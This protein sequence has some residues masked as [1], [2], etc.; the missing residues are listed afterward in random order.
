MYTQLPRQS[1][2]A[3]GGGCK[4]CPCHCRHGCE[5]FR[6]ADSDCLSYTNLDG[7][8]IEKNRLQ[9][10]RQSP[11]T[12]KQVHNRPKPV[13][14]SSEETLCLI[15]DKSLFQLVLQTLPTGS[16]RLVHLV[17]LVLDGD[18]LLVCLVG[19]NQLTAQFIYILRK[20]GE[21]DTCSG[22]LLV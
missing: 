21:H 8:P 7:S 14:N 17:E 1:L 11:V 9:G 10:N 16:S 6:D 3:C 13:N 4:E 22:T 12:C 19:D 20:T 15:A 5:R 2:Q 18:I